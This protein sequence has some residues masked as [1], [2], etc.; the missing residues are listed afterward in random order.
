MLDV[1][2]GGE[3]FPSASLQ[4]C[5]GPWLS[6]HSNPSAHF[7]ILPSF[8][9]AIMARSGLGT[10]QEIE[11]QLNCQLGETKAEKHRFESWGWEILAGKGPR[12]NESHSWGVQKNR[13]PS[14]GFHSLLHSG[15]SFPPSISALEH[16][17]VC[18]QLQSHFSS[19]EPQNSKITAPAPTNLGAMQV[20]EKG[21]L[22]SGWHSR[23]GN[24]SGFK[25]M[26]TNINHPKKRVVGERTAAREFQVLLLGSALCFLADTE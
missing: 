9:T 17:D 12:V 19:K 14:R 18:H 10:L 25:T 22:F 3:C 20:Q 8:D 13:F 26:R 1:W 23:C 5:P 7:H 11:L 4:S 16:Q 15:L 6:C 21:A 24:P 2:R